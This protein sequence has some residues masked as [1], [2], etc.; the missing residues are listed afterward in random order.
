[1]RWLDFITDLMD[2]SLS[3][4]LELVMD[5]E[6][7]CAAIHGVT[8]GRTQL[9]DWSELNWTELIGESSTFNAIKILTGIFYF[10]HKCIRATCE[11]YRSMEFGA[12]P[13]LVVLN[14]LIDITGDYCIYVLLYYYYITIINIVLYY[15]CIVLLE[16]LAQ[17]SFLQSKIIEAIIK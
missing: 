8:K 7:W 5:R 11:F 14:H 15:C 17:Q 13:N 2:M 10:F 12:Q 1:M 3:E 9:S 6:A 4:L 16:T